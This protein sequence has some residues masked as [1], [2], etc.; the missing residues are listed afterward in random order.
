[1]VDYLGLV[2]KI[3]TPQAGSPEQDVPFAQMNALQGL[4]ETAATQTILSFGL[5]RQTELRLLHAFGK[6]FSMRNDLIS[7]HYQLVDSPTG[8]VRMADCP[9]ERR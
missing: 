4:V 6:P 2:G 1:M 8:R 9:G 3:D 5:D 7:R